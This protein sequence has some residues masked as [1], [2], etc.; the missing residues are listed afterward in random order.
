LRDEDWAEKQRQTAT[1]ENRTEWSIITERLMT[2]ISQLFEIFWAPRKTLYHVARDPHII[3]PLLFLT[4]FAGVES[5]VLFTLL[6]P[7]QLK[8]EEF[9]RSGISDRISDSDKL[10]HAEAARQGRALA[11]I[12]SAAGPIVIVLVVSGAFYLA[13]GLGKGASFKSFVAV[14]AFSF[15]PSVFHSIAKIAVL[16]TSERTPLTLLFAGSVSPVRFLNAGTIGQTSYFALSIVDVASIW[17]VALLVIGYG[18]A[19]RDRVGLVPRIAVVGGAYCVI[20][21]AFVAALLSLGI[22]S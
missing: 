11:A 21:V 20:S 17:V 16:M 3:A 13:L 22:S 1:L 5:A 10:I 2:K 8:L 6:D 18:F 19:L 14:T 9:Q 15:I 12:A 4:L 7:G